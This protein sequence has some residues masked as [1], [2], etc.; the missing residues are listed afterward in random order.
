MYF[1]R[2]FKHNMLNNKDEEQ[3]KVENLTL[4]E[5]I[6]AILLGELKSVIYNHNG[7]AYI[8]FLN[9]AIGIEYLGA[10]IDNFPFEEEA[11]SEKRFNGA[12]KKLFKKK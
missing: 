10:C 9:L 4:N 7:A 12:L 6:N 5:S 1:V 8:K 2:H 11:Q 3:K